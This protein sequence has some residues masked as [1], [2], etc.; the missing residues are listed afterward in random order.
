[1]A[2]R[3]TPFLYISSDRKEVKFI[4]S[5]DVGVPNLQKVDETHER[6]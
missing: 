5:T 2:A 4:P 3:R 6:D 1:M